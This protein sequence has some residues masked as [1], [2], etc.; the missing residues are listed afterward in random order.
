MVK[1]ADFVCTKH[2]AVYADLFKIRQNI[3]QVH[4]PLPNFTVMGEGGWVF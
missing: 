2:S 4:S 3:P 1:F